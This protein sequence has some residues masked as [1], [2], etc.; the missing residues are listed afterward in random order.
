MGI[1]FLKLD[2]SIMHNHSGVELVQKWL[3]SFVFV[4]NS[5]CDQ[6]IVSW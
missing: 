6:N 4:I 5:N 2:V 1:L 3:S